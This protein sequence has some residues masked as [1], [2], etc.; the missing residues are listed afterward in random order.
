MLVHAHLFEIYFLLSLPI[1]VHR[2]TIRTDRRISVVPLIVVLL[3]DDD[4][5][6]DDAPRSEERQQAVVVA[7]RVPVARVE[8]AEFPAEVAHF[9]LI[10]RPGARRRRSVGID[11]QRIPVTIERGG[12]AGK[13]QV[14]FH[15]RLM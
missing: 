7:G 1:Q 2:Y 14:D 15:R 8:G 3:V 12:L 4:A 11:L 9:V 10:G 5:A 13:F 6:T